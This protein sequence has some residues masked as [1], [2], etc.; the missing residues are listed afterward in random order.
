MPFW[1][2]KCVLSAINPL[3]RRKGS[4]VRSLLQIGFGNIRLLLCIGAIL[5]APITLPN[6]QTLFIRFFD[7][8]AYAQFPIVYPDVETAIWVGANPGFKVN[9]CTIS[10]VIR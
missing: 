7:I 3:E 2:A 6:A 9:G 1:R 5:I 8:L 4:L 10:T